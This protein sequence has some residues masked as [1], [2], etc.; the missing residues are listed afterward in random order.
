M[1]NKMAKTAKYVKALLIALCVCLMSVSLIACGGGASSSESNADG[2]S[3][4]MQ[5]RKNEIKKGETLDIIVLVEG[6]EDT[7]YVIT[8]D[9]DV[10]SVSRDGVATVTTDVYEDVVV[11]VTATANADT[12]KSVSKNITVKKNANAPV[13]EKNVSVSISTKNHETGASSQVL[14]KTENGKYLRLD[15]RVSVTTEGIEDDSYT[16][17][18][19]VLGGSSTPVADLVSLGSDASS[20]K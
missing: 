18:T 14:R 16:L 9:N 15:I 13:E 5:T 19:E 3:I 1:A 10:L 4:S 20:S 8:T 11:K 12:T 6:A 2:V 17:S 7:S